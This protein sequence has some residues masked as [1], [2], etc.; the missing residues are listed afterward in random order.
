MYICQKDSSSESFRPTENVSTNAYIKLSEL[1]SLVDDTLRT[2]LGE[3]TWWILAE[4]KE[5]N[6]RGD[7]IYFELAEKSESSGDVVARIRASVWR[8]EAI[9]AFRNFEDITGKQATAGMQVLVRAGVTFHPTHGLSLQLFDIDSQH[10]LGQLELQR[11]QTIAQLGAQKEIHL[12]DGKFDTPN[13]REVLPDVIQNIAI[14]TSAS[15]A[16][17]QD[18]VHAL[19]NNPFGYRFS[20][21]QYF[22]I[23][24][25]E[26]AAEAM[27]EQLLAIYN[28]A[29]NGMPT[30]VVVLIRGGGAQ[31]DLLP[32]DQF[33][34]AHALARFPIP[35]I[36]GIGHLKNES[37]ADLV[38][39]TS[40]KTPTQAAE[41]LI[42][43]NRMYEEEIEA[44]REMIILR[45]QNLLSVLHRKLDHAGTKINRGAIELIHLRSNYLERIKENL[46]LNALEKISSAGNKLS[47]H[48]LI[49]NGSV[50]KLVYKQV[51]ALDKLEEKIRLLDPTLLLKRGYVMVM[52]N[53][54]II[55]SVT[56]LKKGD[57]ISLAFADGKAEAEITNLKTDPNE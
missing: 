8:R 41:F 37:V 50:D 53:D 51:H 47:E 55:S 38:V 15:A 21:R 40:V 33:R 27:R 42:D 24:Q 23:L 43:H 32:F 10:M 34:L 13:K 6:E 17:Y 52:K 5:R 57:K 46:R 54:E 48:K 16:G 9:A 1:L 19:E 45:T 20:M 2:T 35:V 30:D 22:S 4:I 36:S 18:F 26:K 31:S 7:Y 39:H 11:R 28:D 44:L 14:I 3:R 29:Q 12:V 56:K 25:G 49:I